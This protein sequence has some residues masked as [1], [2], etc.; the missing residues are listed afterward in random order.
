MNTSLYTHKQNLQ[1]T[2]WHSSVPPA[3]GDGQIRVQVDQFALTANN[4]TYAAFGAAMNYWEFF[5]TG[6]EG[7]GCIPVWGFGHVVQS[8]HSGVAVGE[9]FY[10][11]WPFAT[12]AVL[13]PTK[14]SPQGF[15][16]GAAHRQELHAVYNQYLRCNVDPFYTPDSE[17][18]QALLRPLFIT[19]FL[20]DDF[21]VDNNFFGANILLLSSASSKTAYGTAFQLQQREG[22]QVV[23][24]TSKANK[25]FCESLGCYQRVLTY[26]ELGAL[27]ADAALLYV[28]FAGSAPLRRDIHTRFTNLKYDCAIGAAHVAELG[29]GKDLPGPP[30]VMFF[31]P[32]Q[33]KKRATEW[34]REVLGARM[35]SAWQAFTKRAT[36]AQSPWLQVQQHK[37]QDAA[38]A[39]YAQL[40]AGSS[41]PLQGHVVSL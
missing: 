4:I 30:V 31:A 9:R 10:G 2:R 38:Q 25:S 33:V 14:L 11:Y 3:L 6:E 8:A 15:M 35:L 23:G 18:I 22:V 12:H 28:D 27:P 13:T 7:W 37:G 36:N 39:L 5:P 17:A 21:L 19:S 16:D 41:N 32:A 20:I 1:Q 24:L 29:S 26:E 40:L 34:G